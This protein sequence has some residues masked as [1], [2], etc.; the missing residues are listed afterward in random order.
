MNKWKEE[1]ANEVTTART[2]AEALNGADC[3]IGVSSAGALK[4]EY[5]ASMAGAPIIF[6][7]ANPEPEILPPLARSLRPDAIIATGRSDFANQ[8]NNVMCFPFLFRA[9]LDTRTREI[10]QPML[11][12]AAEALAKLARE[13]VPKEVERAYAGKRFEFGP[14]YIMPTPFD[15]RLLD[16][17]PRAVA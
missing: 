4:G 8:I 5:L 17:V 6:A 7:M 11:I 13:P 9:A 2:L 3:F 1:W 12:A 15:P 14:E 16:V 10:N